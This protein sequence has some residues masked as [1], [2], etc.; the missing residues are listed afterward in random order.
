MADLCRDNPWRLDLAYFVFGLARS[1]KRFRERWRT[2]LGFYDFWL[3]ASLVPLLANE[4][5]FI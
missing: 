4:P 1:V 5:N 2:L 3:S